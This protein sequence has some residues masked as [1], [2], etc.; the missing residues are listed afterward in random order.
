MRRALFAVAIASGVLFAAACGGGGSGTGPP[1]TPPPTQPPPTLQ[2]V[3]AESADGKTIG[4]FKLPITSASKAIATITDNGASSM[5]FD[6]SGRLLVAN[7]AIQ[8][9]TQ[10]ITSGTGPA[11][12]LN[13]PSGSPVS[14]EALAFDQAGNLFAVSTTAGSGFGFGHTDISVISA[15][16]TSSSTVSFSFGGLI[17]GSR[18]T[19]FDRNGNIWLARAPGVLEFSPPF[20][21]G[22]VK[23]TGYNIP[24]EALETNSVAFDAANN[25]YV[26][27]ATGLPS[28]GGVAAYNPPFTTPLTPAFVIGTARPSGGATNALAFDTTGKMYVATSS[29]L[30][31]FSPPFGSTSTPI[32]SL[33]GAFSAVAVLGP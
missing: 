13:P 12:V 24:N 28:G 14:W 30:K 2:V 21:G 19:S 1:S 18:G 26:F 27:E 25:M 8:V 15:P 3:A 7:G 16:I 29:G 5:A 17:L 22:N 20:S 33:P 10:P 11:F 31:V 23:H 6:A 9:F 4:I 32:V